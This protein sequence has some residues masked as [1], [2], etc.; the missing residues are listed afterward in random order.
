MKAT[1]LNHYRQGDVLIERIVRIPATAVPQKPSTRIIL[2]QGE[3]TGHHH[4][5]DTV[6]PAD[7]WK[8]GEASTANR[9]PPT[10]AGALFVALPAGGVVTH[11]EHSE[12]KLPAGNYRITRQREYS[13]K[14]IRNVAD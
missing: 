10:L 3:A 4:A 9:R 14:A 2:A 13:P 12:I 5:L 7:W 6:D 1:D 8:A 11:Q